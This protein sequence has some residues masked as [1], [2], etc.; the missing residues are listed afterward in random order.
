MSASILG[1]REYS[2]SVT[3]SKNAH[4]LNGPIIALPLLDVIPIFAIC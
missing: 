2:Y 4:R 3:I 1:V